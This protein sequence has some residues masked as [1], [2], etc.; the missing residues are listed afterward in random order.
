MLLIFTDG[1]AI[2]LTV[3]G[4]ETTPLISSQPITSVAIVL[5]VYGIETI[6][7][8]CSYLISPTLQ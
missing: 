3:Y 5:T 2:V 4:I 7:L 1:V 8:R 6:N